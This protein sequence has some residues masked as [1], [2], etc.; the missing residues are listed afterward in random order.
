VKNHFNARWYDADTARFV[1][2]DPA[3]DGV[4][5]FAY[6]GNNPLK[7]VD[8]TGLRIL[9]LY[10]WLNQHQ[11]R[12]QNKNARMSS[13][14]RT[15]HN[16]NTGI[17]VENTLEHGG[18]LFVAICNIGNTIRLDN[19]EGPIAPIIAAD[20][21]GID[22]Y[23]TA[24]RSRQVYGDWQTVGEAIVSQGT[25]MLEHNI[26]RLLYDMTDLDFKATRIREDMDPLGVIRRIAEDENFNA[27][28]VGVFITP[29]GN[30][31]FVPIGE[32]PD[33][34]GV[35]KESWDPYFREEG[36][37]VDYTIGNLIGAL[38]VEEQDQFEDRIREW[39]LED[40]QLEIRNITREGGLVR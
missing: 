11:N 33:E 12:G 40:A 9:D 15:Y 17:T 39:R 30:M 34:D 23:W 16:P 4:S 32:A 19:A 25:F 20:I 37:V 8:P 22:R 13:V 18:C 31:H 10:S 6:V 7:Y 1:S 2:E 14:Q 3:R 28:V 21:S 5:W 27:F 26:E 29:L 35:F 36:E 38:I 24:E